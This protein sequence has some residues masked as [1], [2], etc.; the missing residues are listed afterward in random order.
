M[1]W[2]TITGSVVSTSTKFGGTDHGNKIANMFNGVDV[3]DT[4]TIN[5][6]V[7]W[8]FENGSF[9]LRNPADTFSYL[10]TPS[11]I[12][13]NRTLTLPLLTGTDT[14]VVES[15]AQTLSN[16][17]FVTPALGTP[18]SGVATNITG[19]VATTGLT[20]TGTKDTTTFLRGD[21]TWTVVSG[22]DEPTIGSTSIPSGATV[23]TI[24]GLTLTTPDIGTPSA[25]VLTNATGLPQS[26]VTSLVSD[27]ALKSTLA[28]PTFTGTVTTASLDVAG[29]N[30]DNVQ[31]IIND[32]STA[33]TAIDFAGDDFQEISISANTTFTASNYAIGKSKTI[34]I[35]TDATER[36][37]AF[38][39][40]W[41]FLNSSKP[42][43]QQASK[44]GILSLTCQT[45]L[46]G[47]VIAMYAAEDNTALDN[48][49]VSQ[50]A[51]GTDGE[52]IS[53][54]TAGA[55]TT[56]AAGTAT[57]VLTSN[58]AGAVPTFQAAAGGGA[59][60]TI[61]ATADQAVN[62]STTLVNSTYL[63]KALTASHFY[64]GMLIL[65]TNTST[66]ADMDFAFTDI[67][68][69]TLDYFT[70]WNLGSANLSA[71]SWGTEAKIN[72]TGSDTYS[73]YYFQVKV[74]AGGGTLQI[75][76]AQTTAEASDT[77]ILEG[78]MIT[79]IDGG[80]Y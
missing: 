38:P 70:I 36:T 16:K 55:P 62:N 66:S 50:L 65:N 23:T 29:N 69:A 1:A 39:T 68:S 60:E 59:T 43:E 48:I 11:A 42:T 64:T 46:E 41:I 15:L 76:F 2:V 31:N 53:W 21:D 80:A 54:D 61:I 79:L 8:T 14:V 12:V 3:T 18:A 20:A 71:T 78:S 57:H 67:A 13:A 35:T 27:L 44:K 7:S 49:P 45:G 26:G 47:G 63:T 77:K 17:T 73:V 19:L 32:L 33:T 51:D 40:G 4:V 37:L 72:G 58:G 9:Y 30:I 74:P 5:S 34:V 52:L 56:V 10:F 75:Q 25:G 28:S 6:A 24:A 22:Y